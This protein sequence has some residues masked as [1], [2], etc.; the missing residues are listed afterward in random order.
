MSLERRTPMKRT[1]WAKKPSEPK[2]R[3]ARKPIARK[4]S[5]KPVKAP[6]RHRAPDDVEALVL[7]R[8]T[9]AG[10]L[11]CE[12]CGR[13]VRRERRG[14]LAA[15]GGW[16]IHHR[17]NFGMGG[18]PAKRAILLQVPS[19]LVAI[20]G[21]GTTGCHGDITENRPSRTVLL[22]R[23]HLVSRDHRDPWGVPI[24]LAGERLVVLDNDGGY[25]PAPG[26]PSFG[27]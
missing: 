19:L 26:A 14:E 23:G 7:A 21:N 2:P 20:C 27:S 6:A 10:Q 22:E 15:A 11:R 17:M 1:G 13:N 18:M 16:S 4:P 9:V 8:A 25:T 24:L 12:L 5:T 3:P